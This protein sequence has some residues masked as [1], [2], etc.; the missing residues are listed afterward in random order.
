MFKSHAF[1]KPHETETHHAFPL[2]LLVVIILLLDLHS[3]LQIC[4]G[5]VTWSTNYRHRS[6][7]A[8]TAILCCSITANTTAGIVIAIGDRKTRKKEVI[9]RMMRQ[10]LT[11]HAMRKVEK[12]RRAREAE[13]MASRKRAAEAGRFDVGSPGLH[14]VSEEIFRDEEKEPTRGYFRND[15]ENK[16]ERECAGK[17]ED[18]QVKDFGAVPGQFPGTPSPAER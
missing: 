3:I 11:D 14:R 9:E 10:E 5:T 18:C 7:A 12:D 13:E 16:T 1:Y 8:T 17:E 6:A 2:T 4:L 15:K